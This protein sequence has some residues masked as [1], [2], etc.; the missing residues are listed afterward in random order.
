ME[1]A[2]Q[3]DRKA[4][5]VKTRQQMILALD[6]R[7]SGATYDQI[8]KALD[9]PR[10][11]QAAHALVQKGFAELV[12][13]SCESAEMLRQVELRRMNRLLFVLEAKKSDPRT[14][15]TIIRISERIAK[16]HGLDRPLK[17]EASGPDGGPIQT[18]SGPDYSK[19]TLGEK[20]QL[21]AL[22]KKTSAEGSNP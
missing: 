21:E 19:L 2:K 9:P 11:R 10:S 15:D 14:A 7:T 5:K 3:P 1:A 8:G 18:L 16:L 4:T 13:T 12:K 17:I 6:L 22:L 20:L